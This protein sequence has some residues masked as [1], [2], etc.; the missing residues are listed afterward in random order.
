M[1]RMSTMTEERKEN[2]AAS[3][4][5]KIQEAREVILE[6]SPVVDRTWVNRAIN[7]FGEE[8][9][10]KS[11]AKRAKFG[12]LVGKVVEEGYTG[13]FPKEI[14]WDGSELAWET[15]YKVIS[16]EPKGEI[17]ITTST[18]LLCQLLK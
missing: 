1:W 15:D 17:Q 11:T 6:L 5:R 4:K 9:R 14:M 3:E 7:K 12:F 13:T 16:T 10:M 2:I 18:R 8:T